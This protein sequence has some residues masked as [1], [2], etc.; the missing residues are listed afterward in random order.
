[1]EV[2]Q[3]G[4][5]KKRKAKR[6]SKK[7][8]EGGAAEKKQTELVASENGVKPGKTKVEGAGGEDQ[9]GTKKDGKQAPKTRTKAAE[10]RGAAAAAAAAG[11]EGAGAMQ[12][13]LATV[14]LRLRTRLFA[15]ELVLRML[16]VRRAEGG[17][18]EETGA[19][20]LHE[21]RH[22]PVPSCAHV[23]FGCTHTVLEAMPARFCG[24]SRL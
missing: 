15:A 10:G 4:G 2:E 13:L 3:E 6:K 14:A 1:M 16:Q 20:S 17:T 5:K 19:R 21:L 23:V 7:G 9:K 8:T 11:V 12:A 22:L 24:C 18:V